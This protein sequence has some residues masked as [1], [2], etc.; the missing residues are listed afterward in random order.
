MSTTIQENTRSVNINDQAV[1]IRPIKHDD[2]YLESNF[3]KDLT[4]Q[5]KHNRFFGGIKQLSEKEVQRL[6]DVDYHNSMAFVATIE[7]SGIEKEVGVAR[8]SKNDA[9]QSHELAVTVADDFHN[10]KLGEI[11]VQ[12]LVDY[13]RNHG[14]KTI[15][16]IDLHSNSDMRKL[17]KELGMSVRLDPDDSHQ[18]IY[19][20]SVDEHPERVVF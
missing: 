20:L 16:S 18:L 11:L 4:A 7:S 6:C 5:T 13:G 10:T 17:A 15:Y 19:S 9:T 12:T 14:V 1:S 8:Y 2:V 3:I